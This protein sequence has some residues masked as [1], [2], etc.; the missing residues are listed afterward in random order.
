MVSPPRPLFGK[1]LASSPSLGGH[2]GA[3]GGPGW[4]DRA[5]RVR[6]SE[7][8]L[9]RSETVK[10]SVAERS[11]STRFVQGAD[12]F[13]RVFLNRGIEVAPWCS[14]SRCPIELRQLEKR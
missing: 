3:G 2:P 1:D 6:E 4:G 13:V 11:V 14:R 8:R 10:R 5:A 7:D 12:N 9:F